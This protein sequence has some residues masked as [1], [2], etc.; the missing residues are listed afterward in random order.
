[1]PKTNLRQFTIQKAMFQ[2]FITKI[3]QIHTTIFI[4]MKGIYKEPRIRNLVP[5][6]VQKAKGL[7]AFTD[8]PALTSTTEL[9]NDTNHL[10]TLM[11]HLQSL[12]RTDHH[13]RSIDHRNFMADPT[14]VRRKGISLPH[15]T[16]QREL[17]SHL[18]DSLT[19]VN[20]LRD[21]VSMHQ[22]N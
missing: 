19:L 6:E 17:D 10:S 11:D 13:H 14:I 15:F 9:L 12:N 20:L 3:N 8:L 21:Q 7:L 1:M 18:R 16:I 5:L 22:E 4:Q 2:T